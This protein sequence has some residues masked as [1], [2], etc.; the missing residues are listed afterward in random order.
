MDIQYDDDIFLL[1]T[2]PLA[3]YAQPWVKKG[4]LAY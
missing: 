1:Y 2:Q 3:S 4:P